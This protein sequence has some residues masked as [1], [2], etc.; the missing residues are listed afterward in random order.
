MANDDHAAGAAAEAERAPSGEAAGTFLSGAEG[1]VYFV[2]DADLAPF[3]LPDDQ[4]R[5][6]TSR[7]KRLADEKGFPSSNPVLDA[8]QVVRGPIARGWG[9]GATLNP[10]IAGYFIKVDTSPDA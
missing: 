5:R 8:A 7:M 4:A 2:P 3:R 6:L 10:S 9:P 1:A